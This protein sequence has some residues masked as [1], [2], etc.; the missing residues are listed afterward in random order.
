MD[1]PTSGSG[2]TADGIGQM[3]IGATADERDSFRQ[4]RDDIAQALGGRISRGS[5]N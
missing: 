4:W 3:G 5:N 1:I 2:A